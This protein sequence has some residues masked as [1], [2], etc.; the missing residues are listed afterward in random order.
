MY[1]FLAFF[2][3][4]LVSF[5]TTIHAQKKILKEAVER[6]DKE[7]FSGV[8]LVAEN[9]KILF[10]EAMGMRS[11]ENQILLH[12]DDIFELASL[13]KQFTAMMVMICK[14]KGL[15][16]FDDQLSNYIEIPYPDISIRQLLTHTSG[17]PDYQAIMDAHWDKSK[18]AGNPEI[19]EYLR[20]YAPV[21]SFE[22]GEKY[23]YSNTG[24]VM[25]ASLVEKVT[26][27]DF[28][29][30]S[31]TWIFDPLGMQSTAI[32]S[33]EEKA[34]VQT[35]AAGHLKDDI[36][37]YV[38]ANNFHSSDYTIWLGNRKGPGRVSSIVED[39]LKWDQALYTE[40]LVS[41]ETL[42]EAF[43]PIKLGDGFLSY[44]GF[45]WEIKPQSPF[46]KMVMHTGGNPG[47][48]TIIVRYIDENKTIIILNNNAHPDL[49]R[50]VEAATLSLGKW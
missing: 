25:L 7:G 16:D 17:L 36:G 1:R 8:I 33:L 19:L 37:H 29:A 13:S 5:Q 12:E 43:R 40:K 20:E 22:P 47:Y 49:M 18:V 41:K 14:E 38:N 4:A 48:K 50:I 46:G 11:Y 34:Q 28:V 35:F 27:E 30:L 9:G 42:E 31:K 24:Y 2:L 44:Y 26:G 6:A 15:L 45:G 3:L 23:E 32:R 10:E 39:L 21:K